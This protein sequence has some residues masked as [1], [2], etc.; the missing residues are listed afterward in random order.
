MPKLRRASLSCSLDA[1]F[2]I[3]CPA[4]RYDRPGKAVPDFECLACKRPFCSSKCNARHI[5][6]EPL[7]DMPV[8]TPQDT[9]IIIWFT[10]PKS[11]GQDCCKL[12]NMANAEEACQYLKTIMTMED[13]STWQP[14]CRLRDGIHLEYADKDVFDAELD[15]DVPNMLLVYI[16]VLRQ[17]MAVRPCGCNNVDGT[18]C[19]SGMCNAGLETELLSSL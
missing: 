17:G 13:A 16:D 19:Y 11:G 12:S 10:I 14:S 6:A 5:C 9:P 8:E 15:T 1:R 2:C 4:G 3:G 7:K 18:L